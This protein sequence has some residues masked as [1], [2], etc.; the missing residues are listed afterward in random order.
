MGDDLGVFNPVT[1]CGKNGQELAVS[2]QSPSLGFTQL[3]V[4]PLQVRSG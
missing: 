3:S 1:G 2:M 4:V